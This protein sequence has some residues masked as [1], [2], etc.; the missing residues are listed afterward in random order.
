MLNGNKCGRV[1]WRE[2]NPAEVQLGKLRA[3]PRWATAGFSAGIS[4]TRER[5]VSQGSLDW[6]TLE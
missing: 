6:L 5:A 4:P 3:M 1:A 2:R